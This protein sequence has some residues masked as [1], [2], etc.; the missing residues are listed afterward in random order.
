MKTSTI[1]FIGGIVVIGA[2]GAL[3]QFGSTLETTGSEVIEKEVV[4]EVAPEWATDEDA[5]NAAQAVIRKKELEAEEARLVEEISTRQ[6][7][8]D[9]I[10][11]ELGTY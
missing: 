8:L 11:K 3:S 2:T 10:R 9:A 7:E 1:L 5:V 4:K 6:D